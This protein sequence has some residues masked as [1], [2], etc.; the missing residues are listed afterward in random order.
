MIKIIIS[1]FLTSFVAISA[2]AYG[3]SEG[4][5]ETGTYYN[6]TKLTSYGRWTVNFVAEE[7]SSKGLLTLLSTGVDKIHL[8]VQIDTSITPLDQ[9]EQKVSEFKSSIPAV[10]SRTDYSMDDPGCN[11]LKVSQKSVKKHIVHIQLDNGHAVNVEGLYEY[12]AKIYSDEELFRIAAADGGNEV[13]DGGN[14][15]LFI[16]CPTP[17]GTDGVR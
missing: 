12:E 15:S 8:S 2:Q 1:F 7:G 6:T 16:D 10:I 17:G 5:V 11:L 3:C 14:E 13:C 4:W 9:I